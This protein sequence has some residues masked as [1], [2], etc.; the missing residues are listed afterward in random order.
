MSI[1]TAQLPERGFITLSGSDC[2]DFL[3]NIVTNNLSLLETQPS[4][5]A[6]LLTPQGKFLH[7]FFIWKDDD[8]YLIECEA[9]DRVQDLYKRL[10]IYKLRAKVDINI[11]NP[12]PV[13]VTWGDDYLGNDPRLPALGDRS[14]EVPETNSDFD[15]YDQYRLS[16]G[17]SDGS[18]DMII[19]KSTMAEARIDKLNGVDYTKGCY[20]GQEL[21]ARMHYRSLGKKF[22]FPLKSEQDDIEGDE[23]THNGKSIAQIRSKNGTLALA[24]MRKDIFDT[25]PLEDIKPFILD[26]MSP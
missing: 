12:K 11:I 16:L 13:F 7:D 18:R 9:G 15:A 19:E 5:Y 8:N 3:Q 4:I 24:L 6:C 26:W 14:F 21:T 2:F 10:S 25:W 17:V 23:I 22:L 20:V 1:Y